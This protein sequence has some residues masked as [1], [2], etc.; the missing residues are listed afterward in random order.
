MPVTTPDSD[1]SGGAY[2]QRL[3]K[4][5]EKYC[6]RKKERDILRSETNWE[7]KFRLLAPE[8]NGSLNGGGG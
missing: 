6:A 8:F 7:G 3:E 5:T 4:T 1:F 2:H